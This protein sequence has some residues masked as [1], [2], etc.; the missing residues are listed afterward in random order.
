MCALLADHLGK[1][2]LVL[3]HSGLHDAASLENDESKY[4]YIN[5]LLL[6]VMDTS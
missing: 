4:L 3:K 2:Y 1:L 5:K 6:S